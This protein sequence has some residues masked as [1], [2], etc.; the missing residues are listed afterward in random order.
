[1]KKLN[2][3]QNIDDIRKAIDKIDKE[4][5]SLIAKRAGYVGAASKFKKNETA[6]K[7]P[8]RVKAMLQKRAEW[9]KEREIK[10]EIIVKIYSELVDFFIKEEMTKWEQE[11]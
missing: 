4:I 5:I 3:C 1:M 6:V 8:E 9:A 7:A 10:P 11:K 2:E